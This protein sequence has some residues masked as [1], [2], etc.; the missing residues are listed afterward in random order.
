MKCEA[1]IIGKHHL[2]EIDICDCP[3]LGNVDK[4]EHNANTDAAWEELLS[5]GRYRVNR[6]YCS[7]V[8]R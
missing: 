1:C 4:D 8:Y 7:S 2:C 3:C 6:I 5:E